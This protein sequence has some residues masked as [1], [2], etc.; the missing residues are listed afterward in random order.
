MA[1]HMTVDMDDLAG[2]GGAGAQAFDD[3]HIIAV[4]HEADVLAVRLVGD[5][6]AE[7]LGERARLG[8][9]DV[10]Q[11]KAQESSCSCVVANRK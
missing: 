11:R 6:Q 9:W 4:R 2:L 8:L 1:Q 3:T 7:A 10:A 5:L